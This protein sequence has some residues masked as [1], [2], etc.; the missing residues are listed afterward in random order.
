M[1]KTKTERFTDA[2][3]IV[4]LADGSVY[5]APDSFRDSKGYIYSR[6]T[7]ADV[8]IDTGGSVEIVGYVEGR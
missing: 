5:V 4:R 8:A 6:Y 2:V 7:A 3:Y 1:E